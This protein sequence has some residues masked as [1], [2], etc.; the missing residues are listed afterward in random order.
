MY[1]YIATSYEYVKNRCFGIGI[2]SDLQRRLEHLNCFRAYDMLYFVSSW[3]LRQSAR[4]V[5]R[6]IQKTFS[7]TRIRNTFF[8]INEHALDALISALDTLRKNLTK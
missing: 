3:N 2:T 7:S 4:I 1:L 8:R 6:M 5:E